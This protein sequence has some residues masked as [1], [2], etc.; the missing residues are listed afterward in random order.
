MTESQVYHWTGSS[1]LWFYVGLD[2]MATEKGA[3]GMCTMHQQS[4]DCWRCIVHMSLVPRTQQGGEYGLLYLEVPTVQDNEVDKAW[5]LFSKFWISKS[6]LLLFE[7]ML[8]IQLGSTQKVL[9]HRPLL[10][11][12]NAWGWYRWPPWRGGWGQCQFVQWLQSALTGTDKQKPGC[13]DSRA[14]RQHP[15]AS[16]GSTANQLVCWCLVQKKGSRPPTWGSRLTFLVEMTTSGI[17][18]HWL[19]EGFFTPTQ[20]SVQW[21]Y[22]RR[23]WQSWTYY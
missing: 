15:A 6:G 2:P 22:C 12:P 14:E 7:W 21:R 19:C 23:C 10:R 18:W 4:C 16:S 17:M 11:A 20:E 1:Y 13:L 3:V 5:Q 9:P 8:Q